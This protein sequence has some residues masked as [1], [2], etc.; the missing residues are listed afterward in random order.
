[1][2]S[3]PTSTYP[4]SYPREGGPNRPVTVQLRCG[5]SYPPGAARPRQRFEN[6]GRIVTDTKWERDARSVYVYS[7]AE[8]LQ[9]RF[10]DGLSWEKS[11]VIDLK[12]KEI[13]RAGRSI[14]G[15]LDRKDLLKRYERVDRLF[16][17]IQKRGFKR[18]VDLEPPVSLS[19]EL[20][21]SIG[22]SGRTYFSNGGNHRLFI[23]Q[24]LR[25]EKIP[26]LVMARDE[27]WVKRVLQ[28]RD[29]P[30]SPLR[31]HPEWG[32]SLCPAEQ[33]DFR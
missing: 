19:N 23:A 1:M 26:F 11:G 14:D 2:T 10:V 15:A 6:Y 18:Q 12:L 16:D 29:Q 7:L 21:I 33:D 25:L 20:F 27:A 9:R 24:I 17:D 30:A 22:R 4:T 5:L 13:E 3:I 32:N 28:S 31:R 8:C